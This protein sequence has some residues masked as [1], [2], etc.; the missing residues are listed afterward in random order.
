MCIRDSPWGAYNRIVYRFRPL[1]T[2]HR[3]SI[4]EVMFLEPLPEGPRPKAAPI[5]WLGPDDD[6]VE[7]PELGMLA[8]VFNQDNFN[9]PRQQIGLETSARSHVQVSRYNESRLRHFHDL[10]ARWLSLD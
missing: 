1:G 3:Q 4:M 6:W 10:L 8:R 7:A 5:H 2:D 9:L